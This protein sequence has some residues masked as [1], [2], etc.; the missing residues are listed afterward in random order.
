MPKFY[1]QITRQGN[2]ELS[3]TVDSSKGDAQQFGLYGDIVL[4]RDQAVVGFD[5]RTNLDTVTLTV[6]LAQS[7]ARSCIVE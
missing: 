1:G 6:E 5:H 7:K 2:G 3:F 4:P